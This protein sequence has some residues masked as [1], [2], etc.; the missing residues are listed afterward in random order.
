MVSENHTLSTIYVVSPNLQRKNNC[1]KLE[2]VGSIIFL[3]Y[4]ELTRGVSDDFVS[5]HE[6]ATKTTIRG[7][8]IHHEIIIPIRESED[9]SVAKQLLESL[10]RFILL[11]T[12]SKRFIL[13]S[14][15]GERN[16]DL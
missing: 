12:P 6:D 2:V 11:R 15:R 16:G 7:I 1:A 8:T 13:L 3:V 9:R 4:F 10:K 14:Q 5:L